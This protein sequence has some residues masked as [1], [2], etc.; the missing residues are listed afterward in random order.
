M[1]SQFTIA[2]SRGVTAF[3]DEKT[4]THLT[5]SVSHKRL[6]FAEG[7]NL[8]GIARGLFTMH[9]AIVLLEG[10]FPEE[11]KDK[12]LDGYRNKWAVVDRTTRLVNVPAI[13]DAPVEPVTDPETPATDPETVEGQSV[14]EVTLLASLDEEVTEE[15]ATP[16]P[17]GRQRA[18]KTKA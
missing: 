9:P 17:T 13:V 16:K 15:E 3:Y 6:S 2:L 5:R 18:S 7:E 10:T 12:F 1:A 4:R 11:E 14:G 8:Q